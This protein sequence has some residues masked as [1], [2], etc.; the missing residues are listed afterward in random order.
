MKT[1]NNTIALGLFDADINEATEVAY[2]RARQV[3]GIF[4]EKQ[5]FY[6]YNV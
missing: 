2:D 3:Y 1:L 4:E 5:W 6:L